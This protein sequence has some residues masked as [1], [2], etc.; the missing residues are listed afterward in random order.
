MAMLMADH[1]N[2]DPAQVEDFL[3]DD[4]KVMQIIN[5]GGSGF[6]E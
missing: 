2:L 5:R 6:I 3:I 1:L 4:P